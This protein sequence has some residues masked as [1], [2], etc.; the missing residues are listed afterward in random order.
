VEKLLKVPG[1][2]VLFGGKP[3][4]GTKVPKCFGAFECTA[5][6][7]PLAEMIKT[8]ETFELVTSEVFAPV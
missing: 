3:V 5:V 8:K 7:V 1:S 6:Y 2:K 4:T